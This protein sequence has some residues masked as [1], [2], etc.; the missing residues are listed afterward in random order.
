M[1]LILGGAWQ[2]KLELAKREFGLR[3]E[4]V[5]DC[6][7]PEIDFCRRCIRHLEDFTLACAGE[8]LDPVDYF[9]RHAEDWRD[10]VLICR[11][12]FC[13]VVPTDPLMR[14]WRNETARLCKYLA[15]RAE[16]VSRVFCG[17]EQRLK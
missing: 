3:E 9:E 1:I 5:F 16:R 15:D 11:D 8:G 10:S 7:G 2:G 17:L 6:S 4:D 12:V 13:G 14:L